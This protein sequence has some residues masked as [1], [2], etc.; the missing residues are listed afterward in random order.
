[1]KSIS[2]EQL[3]EAGGTVLSLKNSASV[4]VSQV[5]PP[6]LATA[7]SLVFISKGE[8]A[9]HIRERNV[10]AVIVLEKI[11]DSVKPLLPANIQVWTTGNIQQA[12]TKVLPL[13]DNNAP[14]YHEGIHPT[15]VI[16]PTAKVHPRAHIGALSFVGAHAVIGEETVLMPHSYVGPYCEIGKR[17]HISSHTTIGSDGFGFFTD[18][19]FNHHKVPQ[20][21]KVVIEDDCEFGAH[22]AVDRATLTE[23]RIKRGSKFDNLC[24]IA[25]NVE[26]GENALVAAGLM[27]AGSAKVGKNLMTSGGVHILGHL[28]IP[29]NVVL[30]ARAG[31][32]KTIEEPGMYGGFPLESH[33]ESTK[34]LMSLPQVKKIK[35]QV[36]KILNHLNLKD[37]EE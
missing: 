17:C 10:K 21:G 1:M 11:Y 23:T 35:K 19:N 16:H 36:N 18:K 13:F 7:S 32:T 12:M 27:I 14:F 2:V 24:H 8:Q 6:E 30:T 3:S 33:K 4:V 15:A 25:H 5:L 31:V 34:T 28:T 26:F 22:C 37:E 29:D 9:A 20:I